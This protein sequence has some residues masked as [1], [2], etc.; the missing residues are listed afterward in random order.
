MIT[1]ACL[2]VWMGNVTAAIYRKHSVVVNSEQIA[3]G[4]N[5]NNVIRFIAACPCNRVNYFRI[6]Y[7]RN[8]RSTVPLY[9]RKFSH[10]AIT[11]T[12]TRTPYK[13]LKNPAHYC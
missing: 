8:L 10:L 1:T 12:T 5:S 3:Y 11:R 13:N 4:H 9:K 7:S 2:C 6:T